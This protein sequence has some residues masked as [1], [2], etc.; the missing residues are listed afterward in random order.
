MLKRVASGIMLTLIL[1]GMLIL[2][3]KIQPV[4]AAPKSADIN[5][6]GAVDMADVSLVVDALLA[7]PGHPRWNAN[8]DIDGDNLVDLSDMMLVI[9]NFTP[10]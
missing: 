3:L 8:A 4:K 2:A 1:M 6:D 5:Q 7:E 10:P 9:E